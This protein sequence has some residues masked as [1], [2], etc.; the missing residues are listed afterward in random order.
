VTPKAVAGRVLTAGAINAHNT[1]AA[2]DLVKPAAFDGATIKGDSL[3]VR[4]PAKSVVIL[5]LK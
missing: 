1:F 5:A 4:L 2:P 3:E